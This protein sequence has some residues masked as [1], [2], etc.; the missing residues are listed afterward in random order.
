M[1]E[2]LHTIPV[3]EAFESGDECPF[4]YLER[5][6]EEHII[7][8][9][10]GPGASYMELDVRAT[11]DEEGFCR[12]HLKSMFD[13]GNALGCSLILQTHYIGMLRE[14]KEQLDQWDMPPKKS[15]FRKKTSPAPE[16]ALEAW[17]QKRE[18]SCFICRRVE[19][20]RKRYY[21]TF[22]ALLKDAEFREKVE[23]S[24]GFCLRHF[25]ELLEN[26]SE[27]L[28]G[29][30]RQWFYQTVFSLME[31]NLLRVK[32][33]LDWFVAKNDYRNANADWKNSRDA[34]ARSMQKLQGLYPADP[35][36]KSADV[37]SKRKK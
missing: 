5:E 12:K 9:A 24:K 15:L 21:E 1:Q 25:R 18:E 36:Y 28:P 8:Y 37:G 34:L 2:K 10:I 33:D 7:N 20:N 19:E 35:P 31:E 3:N 4:C 16:N 30:H 23:K 6:T 13:Y 11:T 29:S 14:L 27:N 22:F 17:L 26:A 32:E